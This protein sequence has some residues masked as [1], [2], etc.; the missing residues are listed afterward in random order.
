MT[1]PLLIS[2]LDAIELCGVSDK[3][4]DSHIRPRLSSVVLG[5]KIYFRKGELLQWAKEIGAADTGS[6]KTLA[7][8]SI[9][10]DGGKTGAGSSA[11]REREILQKLTS[12]R[13][14]CTPPLYPVGSKSTDESPES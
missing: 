14:K 4:F 1:E 5:R 3:C 12:E 13:S 6:R 11:A 8:G 2:R 9:S 7:R 10:R